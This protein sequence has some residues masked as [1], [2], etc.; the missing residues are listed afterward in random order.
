MRVRYDEY[1]SGCSRAQIAVIGPGRAG[2]TS[3]L[4]SASHCGK[5]LAIESEEGAHSAAR[6]VNAKNL[7]IETLAKRVKNPKTRVWE[8]LPPEQQPPVRERLKELTMKAF[9]GGYEIVIVDGLTDIASKF[10]EEYARK[11]GTVDQREWFKLIEGM[12][13]FVHDLKNGNFH[14]V[15]SCIAAPPK[16]GS[17]VEI[18]PSLPGQLREQ[19]LPMFQSIVLVKYQKKDQR[20]MLVVNDRALGV[21]DR[22]HSF[23]EGVQQVDIT[24]RPKWAIETMINAAKN[25]GNTAEEGGSA[26]EVQTVVPKTVIKKPG[27]VVKPVVR[28][29]VGRPVI[30][31]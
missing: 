9:T 4:Y 31:T 25:F 24:D 27:V 10:E 7:E 28:P 12:K 30:K 3:L 26:E 17:L 18:S 23:G 16:E 5:T 20:C 14:L 6:F 8:A 13:T 22:F 29:V 15:A 2:K 21:C 1:L 19:M 11:T